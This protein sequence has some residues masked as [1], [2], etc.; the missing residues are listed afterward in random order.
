MIPI[1]FI[2]LKLFVLIDIPDSYQENSHFNHLLLVE[3]ISM[4]VS[5]DKGS[6][7]MPDFCKVN[8]HKNILS[9]A[10]GIV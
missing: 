10:I 2:K 5:F 8:S 4:L 7:R 9:K 1:N 6:N 3:N